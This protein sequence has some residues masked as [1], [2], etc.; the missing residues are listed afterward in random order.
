M[1]P[2]LVAKTSIVFL[3]STDVKYKCFFETE[4]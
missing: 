3:K 1:D 2:L 4:V